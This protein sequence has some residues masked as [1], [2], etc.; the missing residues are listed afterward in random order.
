M[1]CCEGRKMVGE[2]EE[3]AREALLDRKQS[4][5]SSQRHLSSHYLWYSETG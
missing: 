4:I 5:L 1:A 2:V 3:E